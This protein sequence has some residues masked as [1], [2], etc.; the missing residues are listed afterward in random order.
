M[1]NWKE[2]IANISNREDLSKF[3]KALYVDLKNK[4]ETWENATLEHYLEA[5]AAY[6]D[7]IDGKYSNMDKELPMQ[8]VWK[9][10]A[11]ILI[12]AKYYE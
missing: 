3:V 12:S 4:P 5:M 9:L 1:T 10:F 7:D 6:I 11:E 8:A 2:L